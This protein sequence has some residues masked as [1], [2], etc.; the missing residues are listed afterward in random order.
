MGIAKLLVAAV[1]ISLLA[2]FG[3][4]MMHEAQ[5]KKL[6]REQ[7]LEQ[8]PKRQLDNVR[9]KALEFENKTQQ[10]FDALDKKTA[11]E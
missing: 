1:A 6:K 7:E 2:Y 10:N 8:G 9:A 11:P 4:H 5:Q 3:Y